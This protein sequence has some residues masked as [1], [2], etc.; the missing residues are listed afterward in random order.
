VYETTNTLLSPAL[1]AF[2]L[3]LSVGDTWNTITNV[4]DRQGASVPGVFLVWLSVVNAVRMYA[5]TLP[6]AGKVLAPSAV[7]ITIANVLVISIWRLN[8]AEPLYPFKKRRE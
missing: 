8:G 4:E 3:H 6:L 1:L 2:V 7:W 5:Q